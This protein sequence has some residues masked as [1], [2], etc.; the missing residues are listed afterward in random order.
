MTAPSTLG[1][2]QKCDVESTIRILARNQPS[3]SKISLNALISTFLVLIYILEGSFQYWRTIQINNLQSEVKELKERLGYVEN[4]KPI[5]RQKRQVEV[6]NNLNEDGMPIR[7]GTY[8]GE[9]NQGDTEGLRIYDAWFQHKNSANI[10]QSRTAVPLDTSNIDTN[11]IRPHHRISALWVENQTKS[12]HD[13]N[14]HFG[15][16]IFRESY[17]SRSSSS[18]NNRRR[19]GNSGVAHFE[20]LDL[21]QT[22]F[23]KITPTQQPPIEE[24]AATPSSITSVSSNNDI[25]QLPV[26]RPIYNQNS[27]ATNK[28]HKSNRHLV[29]SGGASQRRH[30]QHKKMSL[31]NSNNEAVSILDQFEGLKAIHFVGEVGSGRAPDSRVYEGEANQKNQDGVFRQW[32]PA[33]W[34]TRMRMLEQFPLDEEG[35]A[36]VKKSGLYYIYAQVNYL[37]EHDVNAFQ[38]YVNEDPYLLCTV[39]THTRHSTT[40]A[41]TCFTS[42]V[43]FLEAEDQILVRDLEPMRNS[44]IRPA[45]TFFGLVQLSSN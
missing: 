23:L 3:N 24:D 5:E 25:S 21:P 32:A 31:R 10:P 14:A 2:K 43:A 30:R 45:H 27:T 8:D 1:L 19:G 4:L 41:N 38:V 35:R 11:S 6:S 9:D 7:S 20:Q 16:K 33:R 39:M 36:S 12:S 42:G 28:K 15:D 34:A 29:R 26:Q 44:V 18:N 17:P 22:N 40:K 13:L 37:D